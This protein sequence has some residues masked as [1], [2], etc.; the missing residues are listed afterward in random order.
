MNRAASPTHCVDVAYSVLAYQKPHTLCPQAARRTT[1][2][3]TGC[4]TTCRPGGGARRRPPPPPSVRRCGSSGSGT[5]SGWR[6][7]PGSAA[8][9]SCRCGVVVAVVG[10]GNV[11]CQCCH[12]WDDAV[13]HIGEARFAHDALRQAHSLTVTDAVCAVNG[14]LGA[15]LLPW[16]MISCLCCSPCRM[17]RRNRPRTPS[18]AAGRPDPHWWVQYAYPCFFDA[19]KRRHSNSVQQLRQ[20]PMLSHMTRARSASPTNC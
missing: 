14:S 4:G 13:V 18:G 16:G 5:R 9:A 3:P 19:T 15:V 2:G 8:E 1:S 11:A 6:R 12:E 10:S 20:P 17:R 7:R